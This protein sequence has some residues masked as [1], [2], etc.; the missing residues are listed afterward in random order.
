[1]EKLEAIEGIE[2]VVCT[3]YTVSYTTEGKAEAQFTITIN[4]SGGAAIIETTAADTTA[5]EG[6]T[7]AEEAVAAE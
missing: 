2:N 4:C 3:A 6:E 5:A 7:S 1:M